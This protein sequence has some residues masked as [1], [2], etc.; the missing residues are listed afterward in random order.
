[1]KPLPL[2]SA[3]VVLV[4]LVTFVLNRDALFEFAGRDVPEEAAAADA[5]PATV[6]ETRAEAGTDANR[7]SVIVQHSE[8]RQVENAVIVRGRTEAFRQ[9]AV[10]AETSGKVVSQPLRK[11][12]QIEA[13]QV[14]CELDPGTRQVTLA[15][16]QARLA[17][18]RAR[19]PESEARVAEAEARLEEAR[20]N[21][22]AARQ[23]SEGGFASATRVANAEAA[24]SSAEAAVSSAR[25]GLESVRAGIQSAEAAVERAQQD[26]A[27]LTITAPFAGVL[28]SDTAEFGAYLSTQGGNS[29][30]ATVIQLDPIKFVGFIPETDIGKVSL[31]APAGAR[32]ASGREV[33]G[34]VTFLSR[35]ADLTTR[36]FRVEME[37]ANPDLSI[38]D[39]QTAT[40]GLTSE[41]AIAHFIPSSALTLDD[42]GALGI[43]HAVDDEAGG[44]VAAFAPVTILRDTPEGVWVT[45]L[46]ET[47]D[48]IVV[49]QDYVTAGTP[50]TVTLRET[51]S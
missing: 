30:C 21:E 35:S 16:A 1:M 31:R 39:G 33:M 4:A 38:R 51:K 3:V 11:G 20:I 15:E 42:D 23:L 10:L 9:V 6:A 49:G 34:Q 25:T 48:V 50:L 46:P 32:L 40:L 18:A 17:E 26:I 36:T 14:L 44:K 24:L 7:V 45:G 37:V 43:R 12:A 22:N 28:E 29:T 2:I 13:G 8:A 5:E 19:V 47:V 27:H 41:G